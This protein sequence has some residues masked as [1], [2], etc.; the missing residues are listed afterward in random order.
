MGNQKKVAGL[1]IGFI[2]ML[3]IGCCKPCIVKDNFELSLKWAYQELA[4]ASVGIEYP[5][6]KKVLSSCWKGH[7]RACL[8]TYFDV[9]QGKR[10]LIHNKDS[11]PERALSFTLDTICSQCD[12]PVD[13]IKNISSEMEC[14]GAIK[15]LYFFNN[16]AEDMIIVNRLEKASPRVLNWVL[17]GPRAEWYH[18]RPDPGRWIEFVNRLTDETIAQMAD[19]TEKMEKSFIIDQFK[20][21]EVEIEPFGIMF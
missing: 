3:I 19:P 17:D 10:V 4:L 18:N 9:Q 7:D 8:D 21:K 5:P 11:D 1:I 6:S 15:A 16:P 13:H 12:K 14:I 2:V 20:M